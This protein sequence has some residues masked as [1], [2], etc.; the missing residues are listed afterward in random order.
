M[1][2]KTK[3]S[4][5]FFNH[6]FFSSSQASGPWGCTLNPGYMPAAPYSVLTSSVLPKRAHWWAVREMYVVICS[7][8]M[9]QTAGPRSGIINCFYHSHYST[10]HSATY[11]TRGTKPLESD[12]HP[13]P[14]PL[15]LLHSQKA[16][17]LFLWEYLRKRIQ[18]KSPDA[19]RCTT[20]MFPSENTDSIKTCRFI[21]QTFLIRFCLR[22][23]AECRQHHSK[24]QH[25]LNLYDKKVLVF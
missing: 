14:V 18:L 6:F 23:A 17:L 16:S 11:L 13:Y 7:R 1:D 24:M 20:I 5:H 22:W 10:I 2:P 19:A 25:I 8:I 21:L 12:K 15:P 9:A 3:S 4:Q